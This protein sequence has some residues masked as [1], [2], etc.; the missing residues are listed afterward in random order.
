MVDTDENEAFYVRTRGR[1]LGPFNIEQLK[2]LRNRGQFGRSHEISQDR[3][4]WQ[5]ANSIEHLL[6]DTPQTK[7]SR[8]SSS[9]NE[10]SNSPPRTLSANWYYSAAGE[11]CGPVTIL[12]I[13][14]LIA[15]RQLVAEDLVWKEGMSDWTPIRDVPELKVEAAAYTAAA[16]SPSG[17]PGQQTFCY[18]CGTQT[19]YRAEVCPKCGV[20]Q[21]HSGETKNRLTASLLALFLGGFGVHHFYL[22]N[23]PRAVV[24]LLFC[25]TFIPAILALIDTIVLMCMSEATFQRKYGNR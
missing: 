8:P 7:S 12:D 17:T 5:S 21:Q 18:A 2:Q 24:Y 9:D 1:I 4:T 3:Q 19:D 11:Q 16:R 23:I 25:W 6:L 15:N 14:N 13:R 22:G 20:R 10:E